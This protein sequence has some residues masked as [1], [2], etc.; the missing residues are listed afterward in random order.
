MLQILLHTKDPSNRLYVLVLELESHTFFRIKISSPQEIIERSIERKYKS[1]LK[2]AYMIFMTD[3]SEA[4]K[5]AKS[6]K[7]F[8]QNSEHFK[9]FSSLWKDSPNEVKDEYDQVYKILKRNNFVQFVHYNQNGNSES[10]INS[11][12]SQ[13]DAGDNGANDSISESTACDDGLNCYSPANNTFIDYLGK[14]IQIVNSTENLLRNSLEGN[15][16]NNLLNYSIVDNTENLISSL[17]GNNTNYSIVDNTGDLM[18]SLEGNDNNNLN[19][20]SLVDNT[21]VIKLY[22]PAS[23]IKFVFHDKLISFFL[24]TE[25]LGP[26]GGNN[27][28]NLNNYSIVDNTVNLISSFGGNNTNYSIVDNT[29]DLMSSFGGNNTNNLNNYPIIDNAGNL[30]NSFGENHTNNLNNY[31]IVNTTGDL[32]ISENS[33]GSLEDNDMILEADKSLNNYQMENLIMSAD[34][35]F[36]HGQDENNLNSQVY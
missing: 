25:T 28:N 12:V 21:Y 18:S 24:T 7:K 8:R 4:F 29:D 20:Y 34:C 10:I 30:I 19:S 33:L 26:F 5:V 36:E 35:L 15:N 11:Q 22:L 13:P 17:E 2:N 3:C 31:Q 1:P 23:S 16:T 27:T 14:I 6:E 9:D 32:F